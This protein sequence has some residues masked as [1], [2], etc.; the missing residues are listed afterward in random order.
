MRKMGIGLLTVLLLG[1]IVSLPM[2]RAQTTT[3]TYHEDTGNLFPDEDRADLN[4]TIDGNVDWSLNEGSL[5]PG[6]E[7]GRT[8]VP[9]AGPLTL[10]A[11]YHFEPPCCPNQERQGTETVSQET[12]LGCVDI[13][14]P[15][16]GSLTVIVTL[17]GILDGHWPPQ[18]SGDVS[19]VTGNWES[20]TGQ[21]LTISADQQAEGEDTVVLP[22]NT[23]YDLDVSADVKHSSGWNH[24]SGQFTFKDIEGSP[25]TFERMYTVTIEDKSQSSGDGGEGDAEFPGQPLPAPAS[26]VALLSLVLVAVA[27][28]QRE[29]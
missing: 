24:S 23:D 21:D 13:P 17:C 7:L 5:G 11:D 26:G 22:V 15:V 8:L 28:R 6:E 16:D 1:G 27:I 19:P 25:S 10:Q 2:A 9:S 14:I 3:V 29:A 18:G 12:P 20:Y 4:L